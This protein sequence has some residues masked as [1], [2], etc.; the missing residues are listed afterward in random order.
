MEQAGLWELFFQTG[1]PQVWLAIRAERGE[2][3]PAAAAIAP[4]QEQPSSS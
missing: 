2:N 1:L 4:H 3:G